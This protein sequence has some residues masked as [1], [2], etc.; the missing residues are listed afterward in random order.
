ML[1]VEDFTWERDGTPLVPPPKPPVPL[2]VRLFN[3]YVL[4]NLPPPPP[5]PDT[6]TDDDYPGV[7]PMH[8][9]EALK[10]RFKVHY[11]MLLERHDLRLESM[12]PIP[13]FAA[14]VLIKLYLLIQLLVHKVFWTGIKLVLM[15]SEE[16]V[17]GCIVAWIV[18]CIIRFKINL[19]RV[20]VI[21]DASRGWSLIRYTLQSFAETKQM[22]EEEVKRRREGRERGD[23]F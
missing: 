3:F 4:Q 20:S 1:P 14:C 10:T 8:W 11:I 23:H 17:L 16:Y 7:E 19:A 6:C 5:P 18:G 15:V 21:L 13:A 22:F 2:D 12:S 9:T